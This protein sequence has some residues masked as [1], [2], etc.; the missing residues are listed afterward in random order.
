MIFLRIIL[1]ILF[2]GIMISLAAQSIPLDLD[3]TWE[4][5]LTQEEGG[6]RPEYDMRLN[7]KVI[8]NDLSGYVEIRQRD[9]VYIKTEITGKVYQGF[10]LTL[11]DG[12]VLNQKELDNMSYCI[13]TYQLF[14]KRKKDNRYL[15]G[16][17]Q[18][19]V[20][21]MDCV[22]G[23]IVLYRKTSRA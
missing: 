11:E 22:P 6:V 13:K 8:G 3:G 23:R 4:G 5:I 16:K 20:D 1:P 2:G 9:D 10:F 12:L 21:G 18:G 15:Q 7:L 17:W 14:V 19:R